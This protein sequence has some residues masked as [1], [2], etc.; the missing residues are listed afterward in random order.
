MST[1]VSHR[2][3]VRFAPRRLAHA[4]LFV[5]DL[6]ESLRFYVEV[7]GL[8]EVFREPSIN[9]IFLSNGSSHHDIAIMG[10]QDGAIGGFGHGARPGLNHLGFEMEH[11][12]VL[13]DAY[14]RAI[15]TGVAI[16]VT[17]DHGL[18]H[19][20][21]VSDSERNLLEFYADATRD[22]RGF[23]ATHQGQ[24]ITSL[25]N[26]LAQVPSTESFYELAFEARYV[27]AAP[28][29]PR[30]ITQ[31]TLLVEDYDAMRRFYTDVAGLSVLYED[32]VHQSAVFGGTIG[33]PAVAL[34]EAGPGET[35]GLHHISFEVTDEARLRALLASPDRDALD[36]VRTIDDGDR[37]SIALRSPDNLIVAFHSD[38]RRSGWTP[39]AGTQRDL[40]ML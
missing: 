3:P 4:N 7:C 8:A 9:A 15:D 24:M 10:I 34:L 30:Q 13:V 37:I 35:P 39:P 28:I 27:P 26:P 31:A 17:L 14:R 12:T 29:R 11:E 23:Y 36:V 25:W 2:V 33:Q 19:S 32:T 5:S 18:S 16:N 21:Y 6:Q 40:Y 1:D 20:V 38:K 22:W